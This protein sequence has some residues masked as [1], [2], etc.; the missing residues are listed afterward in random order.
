MIS[1]LMIVVVTMTWYYL[2]FRRKLRLDLWK[3]KNR[4]RCVK[5]GD[6][7]MLSWLQREGE[8]R[9]VGGFATTV[10]TLKY[11]M[12]Q[13]PSWRV[14]AN[15]HP[16]PREI[17][18]ITYR[19][20]CLGSFEHYVDLGNWV[21]LSQLIVNPTFVVVVVRIGWWCMMCSYFQGDFSPGVWVFY[22]HIDD[23]WYVTF[24]VLIDE[25]D[26]FRPGDVRTSYERS[27]VV[28]TS[29]Q[30][31]IRS[32]ACRVRRCRLKRS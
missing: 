2:F 20:L 30:C 27:D 9:S 29:S 10:S 6:S 14:R 24:L 26:F 4:K 23:D 7:V 18:T 3:K 19:T 15:R 13:K 32:R 5:W 17:Q 28:R 22:W 31:M 8:W 12:P 11:C 21:F 1:V 16:E 25:N